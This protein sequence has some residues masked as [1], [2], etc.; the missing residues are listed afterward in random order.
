MLPRIE[1]AAMGSFVGALRAG[2]PNPADYPPQQGGAAAG[3]G[4]A[5]PGPGM[6]P[7]FGLGNLSFST[8]ISLPGGGTAAVGTTT[9]AV[10]DNTTPEALQQQ[11]ASML[12]NSVPAGASVT[13]ATMAHPAGGACNWPL[14]NMHCC[15][16]V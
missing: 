6:P 11:L 1:D 13:V 7:G 4:A 2:I 9:I 14:L 15:S 8:P 5:A 12:A 16:L 10:D 3:A